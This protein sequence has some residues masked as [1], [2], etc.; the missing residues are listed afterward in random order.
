MKRCGLDSFGV[1][2]GRE[3]TR[4]HGH[5]R[6]S[7]TGGF[8]MFPVERPSEV[9]FTLQFRTE[10]LLIFSENRT[11]WPREEFQKRKVMFRRTS[12]EYLIFQLKYLPRD[13]R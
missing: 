8:K 13:G 11:I 1:L 3:Q 12:I 4:Q 6:L 10:P 5:R 7:R 9:V 2:Q